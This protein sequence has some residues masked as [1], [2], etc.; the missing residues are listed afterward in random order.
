MTNPVI[1]TNIERILQDHLYNEVQAVVDKIAEL[2]ET[3]SLFEAR[4]KK[5]CKIAEVAGIIF[6]EETKWTPA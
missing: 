3:I 1:E 2:N 4:H 6:P 5:L